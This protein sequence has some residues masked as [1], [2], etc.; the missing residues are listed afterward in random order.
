MSRPI[1]LM[2][3]KQALRDKRFRDSLPENFKEDIN[4]FLN[5]PG[6]ACNMPIYKKVMN[7]AKQ[8][9]Q[10]YYPGR[11]VSQLDEEIKKLADNNWTVINCKIDELEAKLRKLA[12]GRKQIAMSR[13][14]DMV[15]VIVNELDIIY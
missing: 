9:I 7:E 6:C 13:Y 3:V 12:P 11:P 15:T 8:Q 10:Q 2:D 5:N 14:E 4:K 1:T